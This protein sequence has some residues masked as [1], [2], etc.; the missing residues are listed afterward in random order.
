MPPLHREAAHGGPRDGTEGGRPFL[1]PALGPPGSGSGIMLLLGR[2]LR[3]VLVKIPVWAKQLAFGGRGG[4]TT[5][6]LAK[7][8][9]TTR[10]LGGLR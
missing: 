2:C 5:V 10:L 7:V 4:S 3:V 8:Y 6:R 9:A 1:P